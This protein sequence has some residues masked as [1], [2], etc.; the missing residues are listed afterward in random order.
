VIVVLTRGIPEMSVAN[1]LIADLTAA[2]HQY[3]VPVP[4]AR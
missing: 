1:R 4:V 3:A 2:I